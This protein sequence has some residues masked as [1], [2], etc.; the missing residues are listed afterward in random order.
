M[1]AL[2]LTANPIFHSM[3]KHV[4]IDIHFVRDKV[5]AKKLDFRFVPSIDK[6]TDG[7]TKPLSENRFTD[8]RCKLGVLPSSSCLRG[9]VKMSH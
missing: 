3:S 7:L 1:S 6:L 9:D 5:L 4:E 8:M 2:S